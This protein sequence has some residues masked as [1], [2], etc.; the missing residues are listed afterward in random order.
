MDTV[1]YYRQILM[2]QYQSLSSLTSYWK[3]LITE[4]TILAKARRWRT[5]F[6]IFLAFTF[7]FAVSL[8]SPFVALSLE[9]LQKRVIWYVDLTLAIILIILSIAIYLT[10]K[11]R[12]IRSS[13]VL[14]KLYKGI[15]AM[16]FFLVIIYLVFPDLRW[17]ILVIGLTW[18]FFLLSLVLEDLTDIYR[19]Q[20]KRILKNNPIPF[21]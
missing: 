8:I 14:I 5:R 9:A 17:E 6:K 21:Q 15:L 19:R 12:K 4:M 11:E 3:S 20:R 10:R 1:S 7:T 13:K 2:H 16:P 18:R